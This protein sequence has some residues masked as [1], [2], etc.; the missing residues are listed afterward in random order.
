MLIRCDRKRKG[1][2]KVLQE[3][4]CFAACAK[5]FVAVRNVL[6]VGK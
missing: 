1:T 5:V 6:D 4:G 3:C 2:A